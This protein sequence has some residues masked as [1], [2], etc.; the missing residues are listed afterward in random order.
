MLEIQRVFLYKRSRL[1]KNFLLQKK[2]LEHNRHYY[3]HI[4]KEILILK[5]FATL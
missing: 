1:K 4:T 5:H 3:Q 2:R